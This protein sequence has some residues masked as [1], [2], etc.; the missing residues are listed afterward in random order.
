MLNSEAT[1]DI[2]LDDKRLIDSFSKYIN[3]KKFVKDLLL[4]KIRYNLNKL[5]IPGFKSVCSSAFR[6]FFKVQDKLIINKRTA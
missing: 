3:D 4:P 5:N 2:P 1:E 6:R